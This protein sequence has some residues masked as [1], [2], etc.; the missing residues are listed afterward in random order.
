MINLQTLFKNHFNTERISD[1][2]LRK[3]TEIHIQ[4]LSANNGGGDFTT[5]ITDTTNVYTNY[6]GAITDEDLKYAVQQ[7]LTI[8]MNNSVENFKAA[9]KRREGLIRSTFGEETPQYQEFFPLGISEYT[10]AIL[11]NIETLMVRFKNLANQYAVELGA[12]LEAEI[13]ALHN[14]F[15]T[16]RTAQLT[17]I[18][19]VS[20]SKTDTSVKRDVVEIELIKNV[21]LIGAM[22]PG[23]V[24]RCMD[25]F[26]QSF[27][28]DASDNDEE[29][30]PPVV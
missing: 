26:D 30:N 6:F 28:R 15:V 17:K 24:N 7:G 3:F 18:G 25:F 21:H 13:T 16:A 2:N 22:F 20:E 12:A 8:A 29:D 1:D 19:E 23:D 4:R 5:M 14:T 27:I 9:V 11:A 10:T